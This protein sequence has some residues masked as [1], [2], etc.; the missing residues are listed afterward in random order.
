MATTAQRGVERLARTLLLP[1]LL[2]ASPPS[3]DAQTVAWTAR[4]DGGLVD[5]HPS[6]DIHLATGP[7]GQRYAVAA[8]RN[9]PN[10]DF[11]TLA[12]DATG[13]LLW[14]RLEDG[15]RGTDDVP[16][17]IS[18]GPMGQVITFGAAG[19]RRL[20]TVAYDAAGAELWKRVELHPTST[21][22]SPRSLAVDASGRAIA[23]AAMG[24]GV[25]SAAWIVA[26]DADGTPL[27][28][29]EGDYLPTHDAVAVDPAGN[30]V[31]AG[32]AYSRQLRDDFL[33][34]AYDIDGEE[35]WRS[36]RDGDAHGRDAVRAL[37]I[38]SWGRF[39]VTGTS[40]GT[41]VSD[42]QV[43]TVAYD[44][45]GT[46]LWATTTGGVDDEEPS[47]LVTDTG[48]NVYVGGSVSTSSGA[49]AWV[50]SLDPDGAE[51]WSTTRVDD[52]SVT[53]HYSSLQLLAGGSLVAGGT[54][55][56][57]LGRRTLLAR[58]D[59]ASGA[60][61]WSVE[62]TT[63]VESF[64]DLA[65]S[66]EGS[67]FAAALTGL[68]LQQDLLA[69]NLDAYGTELWSRNE[70]EIPAADSPGRA[71]GSLDRGAIAA[72]YSDRIYVTGRSF[73][74][75]V[76][77]AVTVAWDLPSGQK[78]WEA[79]KSHS[80]DWSILPV[81]LAV[82]PQ[83]GNVY[84]AAVSGGTE[85]DSMLTVAYDRHG[86]ELWSRT[87]SGPYG[88]A[89]PCCIAVTG[90]RSIVV[91]G[92]TEGYGLGAI[93]VAYESGGNELWTDFESVE[94]DGE[95]RMLY[96]LA[97]G[98]TGTIYVGG[99]I[100]GDDG[101]DF[102]TIA[103]DPSG[104]RL[105]ARARSAGEGANAGIL[106]LA[107]TPD[108]GVVATG[109]ADD[110]VD[111]DSLTVAYSADGAERWAAFADGGDGRQDGS[112]G[113]AVDG[114]GRTYV[115]GSSYLP[116]HTDPDYLIVAYDAEGQELWKRRRDGGFSGDDYASALAINA[117]GNL[118]VTGE[119]WNSSDSDF[120]T[121]AYSPGGYELFALRYDH[122]GNDEGYLALSGSGASCFVG[123]MS[124]GSG[125]DFYLF[126]LFD[127]STLFADGFESGDV[128]LWSGSEP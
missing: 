28:Q 33:T 76:E 71:R 106:A 51:R 13:N 102:R 44:L 105:W 25:L 34:V 109:P 36:Y 100:T 117:L 95:S 45:V 64:E 70:P 99:Q 85:G 107:T 60:E 115:I 61:E 39:L 6:P 15:Y 92:T 41:P 22:T 75:A 24:Q 111:R 126:Q 27:W 16:W 31:V 67:L 65:L 104:S 38:D 29:S 52:P 20:L 54:A 37:A 113:V 48:G 72:G 42:Q 125:Q 2:A 21:W 5:S 122:G 43:L 17:G 14:H 120:L 9:G 114:A 94:L 11:M 47:G 91:A 74:G 69:L 62:G 73:D 63:T 78:L 80:I 18:V 108:G 98:T 87:K 79:R 97:L 40:E 77:D 4:W 46:E 83:N 119:S 59:S 96:S 118:V 89:T 103:L 30:L 1:I 93:T 127:E 84:V 23:V 58:L 112:G 7:D 101:S 110:W 19:K 128:A 68:Y 32:Q 56:G 86:G 90:D 49:H 26:Y 66:A 124:E 57:D 121:V 50:V 12:W 123:G 81:A 35:L 8:I 88:G 10:R 53:S 55:A 116:D 82:D 3:V